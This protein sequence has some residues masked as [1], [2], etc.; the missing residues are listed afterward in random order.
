MHT[1]EPIENEEFSLRN[2]ENLLELEEILD[3]LI[4]HLEKDAKEFKIIYQNL[5]I[6]Y[7]NKIDNLRNTSLEKKSKDFKRVAKKAKRVNKE[8]HTNFK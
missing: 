4:H 3:D 7:Y 2:K 5:P 1:D 6:K 8:F